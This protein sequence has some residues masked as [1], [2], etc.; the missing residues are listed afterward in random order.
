M[1]SPP[2]PR[3]VGARGKPRGEVLVL[4]AVRLEVFYD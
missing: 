2:G 1:R 3:S 4:A